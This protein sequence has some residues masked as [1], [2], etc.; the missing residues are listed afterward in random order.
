MKL[1]AP[2]A[3]LSIWAM[4][5][6]PAGM[7]DRCPVT[8]GDPAPRS[9]AHNNPSSARHAVT[10][11]TLCMANQGQAGFM[12]TTT[13][14]PEVVEPAYIAAA[15]NVSLFTAQRMCRDGRFPHAFRLGRTG[16]RWRV[17]FEDV[18]A[19]MRREVCDDRAVNYGLIQRVP[20]DDDEH[21]EINRR[22]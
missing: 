22:P 12:T 3:P 4:S 16:S 2:H 20:A 5:K 13:Q 15:L 17:P 14:L 21:P 1:A 19:F 7:A 18:L 11:S 10:A 8:L 6:A 9:A